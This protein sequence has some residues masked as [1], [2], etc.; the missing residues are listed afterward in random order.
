M[1]KSV[2]SMFSSQ[3]IGPSLVSFRMIFEALQS[4]LFKL[5]FLG[6]KMLKIP[7][8]SLPM[9]LWF[10]ESLHKFFELFNVESM[11]L[12]GVIFFEFFF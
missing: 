9:C 12:I 10:T 8:F 4:E 2:F 11:I 5:Y 1:L 7:E 3:E 6:S